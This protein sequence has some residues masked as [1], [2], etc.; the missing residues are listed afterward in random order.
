MK[1]FGRPW[2]IA[3]GWALDLYFGFET[4]PHADVD[5][6][7]LRPDQPKLAAQVAGSQVFKVVAGPPSRR[8]HLGVVLDNQ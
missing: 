3:G 8:A 2:A 5:I 4:R 1:D 6:A 7:I